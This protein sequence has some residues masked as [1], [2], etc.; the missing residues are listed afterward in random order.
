MLKVSTEDSLVFVNVVIVSYVAQRPVFEPFDVKTRKESGYSRTLLS[1][2]ERRDS[3]NEKVLLFLGEDRT[4][5]GVLV[6]EGKC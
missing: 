1:I 2:A 3:G 5:H 6:G 4:T